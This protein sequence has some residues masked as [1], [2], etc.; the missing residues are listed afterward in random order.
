MDR[1]HFWKKSKD[2]K[3]FSYTVHFV[4]AFNFFSLHVLMHGEAYN[5]FCGSCALDSLVIYCQI[6]FEILRAISPL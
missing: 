3:Y 6:I 2:D 1:S 4:P 5:K